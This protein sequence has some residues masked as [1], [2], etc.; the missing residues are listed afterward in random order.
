MFHA[1]ILASLSSAEFSGVSFANKHPKQATPL[2]KSGFF[3]DVMM[4]KS[5]KVISDWMNFPGT[6]PRGKTVNYGL[7]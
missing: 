3:E 6:S 7:K 2:M 4:I 1:I 5:K